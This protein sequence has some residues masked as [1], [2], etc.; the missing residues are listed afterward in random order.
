MY[1]A[2]HN[3]RDYNT[4]FENLKPELF[5][6]QIKHIVIEN[7]LILLEEFKLSELSELELFI[8]EQITNKTRKTR[9]ALKNKRKT[10]RS[11][12]PV[13]SMTKGS[14]SKGSSYKILLI[15]IFMIIEYSYLLKLDFFT[16][17]SYSILDLSFIGDILREKGDVLE[18]YFKNTKNLSINRLKKM[19]DLAY[20]LVILTS[21]EAESNDTTIRIRNTY[22]DVYSFLNNI[23]TFSVIRVSKKMGH[24]P[25]SIFKSYI[26]DIV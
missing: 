6:E 10:L 25:I 9:K 18:T 8:T 4:H 2:L 20:N 12:S 14:K 7:P 17:Y 11:L 24:Y 26:R 22:K 23:I 3:P 13:K 21:Q 1:N 5:S 19:R 15:E 16:Q